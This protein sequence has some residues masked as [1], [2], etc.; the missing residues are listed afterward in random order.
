M[1]REPAWHGPLPLSD[2]ELADI[3][4][5]LERLAGGDPTVRLEELATGLAEHFHVLNRVAS[6]DL[7]ARIQR[8]SPE[9]ILGHL[10]GVTNK[11]ID[12]LAAALASKRRAEKLRMES[13]RRYRS[14]FEKSADA[15]L[16]I[17]RDRI[18]DCN[19]ACLEL[20]GYPSKEEF[21]TLRPADLTPEHQSAGQPSHD[22]VLALVR[23]ALRTGSRRFQLLHK[24]LDGATFHAEVL[25]TLI[26]V[27]KKRLLHAVVR[28][29]TAAQTA[30]EEQRKLQFQLQ[31]AQK[32]EA[33]GT[34]AGGIAHDFNNALGP[35]IGYTEM[36]M[37]DLEEGSATRRNLGHVLLS[38]ERARALVQQ[39]M[40]FSRDA[41]VEVAPLN[42]TLVVAETVQL[43]RASLPTT[44]E[45]RTRLEEQDTWVEANP[46]HIHQVVMNLCTNAAHAL[47]AV[48]GGL[49]EV[50]LESVLLAPEEIRRDLRLQAGPHVSLTV[51]DTGGGIPE[52]IRGRIFEP[53]FTTKE[54][55]EGSGMGLAMVHG[56]VSDLGGAVRVESVV[57]EG[58]RFQVLL[59]RVHQGA[60]Y[61]RSS[62]PAVRRPGRGRVLLVDD[63]Q[64]VVDFI[65]QALGRGG[66]QVTA[67]TSS[68]D[69]WALFARDPG[70]FDVVV[71]DQTM[72]RLTGLSLAER[73]LTLRPDLPVILCSG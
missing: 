28:D 33:I 51:R 24:R 53:F 4:A 68:E 50:E 12:H 22:K 40:A 1:T 3:S 10:K 60:S 73:M 58:T 62:Q 29:V 71:T 15:T 65:G 7:S 13:E 45:I 61:T 36:A 26:P 5:A 49:L 56:V 57:G 46:S 38:A 2:T 17:D 52:T 8:D 21:L 66:Y 55:G 35:I 34:L 41:G 30:A 32:L 18:I 39:I 59:P 6:G 44:I 27:A 63:E 72:P 9:E 42:A 67:L 70:A 31:Q 37:D 48:G 11:T 23:E 43:L 69:A 25:L 16:V 64:I 14:L 47:E 19:E 54:V 20:F